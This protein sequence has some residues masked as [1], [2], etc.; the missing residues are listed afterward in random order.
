MNVQKTKMDKPLFLTHLEL[1]IF[2]QFL[3]NKVT[4]THQFSLDLGISEK[5]ITLDNQDY[6]RVA[7][8]KIPFPD[9]NI[10][11]DDKRT[12]LIYEE[13]S[14]KPWQYFSPETQKLYKMIFVAPHI[15]PTI[16]ISGIKMHITKNSNPAE[17]TKD[18]LKS[19]GKINGIVLDT[20]MGLGYTA[21]EAARSPYVKM[22]FSC[23]ADQN[24]YRMC[25]QNPWSK[26]IF[27]NPNIKPEIIQVETYVQKIADGFFTAIIHDP[28]R[29][30]LAPQLY[31][32][33]LY[34]QLFRILQRGGRMY[35]YTG[36]PNKRTRK[37]SL[38]EKTKMLL[39]K[40]GFRE[41]NYAYAGVVSKK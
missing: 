35:H 16:E 22:V 24:V 33:N 1:V 20:C 39:E 10:W 3:K 13:I 41:V 19:L 6:F 12:I 5:R 38:A 29:F 15:P 27:N 7:D 2:Q 40:V 23:E 14:W 17:D 11:Q 30:A 34:Q 8:Q 26:D 32:E 4:Q 18:K 28:P 21:I 25:Q 37:R 31:A 9:P 36:D